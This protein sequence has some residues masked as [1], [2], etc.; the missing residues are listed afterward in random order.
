MADIF[1]DSNVY[2]G[3]YLQGQVQVDPIYQICAIAN[4]NASNQLEIS[5]WINKNGERLNAGLNLASYLIKDKSGVAVA[6]LTE[7]NLLP[8]GSGYYHTAP[9]AAPLIYDL[10][11][12]ILEIEISAEG[13]NRNG[14][15]GLVRGE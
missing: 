15:I 12:Y 14:S 1:T 13:L 10:T 2:Q 7:S 4:I 6:G 5:F 8:D 9:I 11:H 3:T